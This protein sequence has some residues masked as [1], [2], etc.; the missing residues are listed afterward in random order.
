MSG[1][2][3]TTA[4]KRYQ[5]NRTSLQRKGIWEEFQD[6]LRQYV[7]LDHTELVPRPPPPPEFDKPIGEIYYLSMHRVKKKSS[8]TTKLRQPQLSCVSSLTHRRSQQMESHS[9]T[10]WNQVPL[11]IPICPP[12]CH[13]SGCLSSNISKMFREIGLH[14]SER[15]LHRFLLADQ[16]GV[17]SDY[18]MKRLTFGVTSSPFLATRVLH[19]MAADY[20]ENFMKAAHLILEAL[21]DN[22]CLTRA[23]TSE[24]ANS[25][26]LE[27]NSLLGHRRHV[28]A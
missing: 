27:L 25:I 13:I 19:Q 24:E 6:K 12:L 26:R 3:R 1:E 22:Y 15:Y 8:T 18:R 21:N 16:S 14:P 2:F 4:Y 20:K 5:E 10:C 7:T 23:D 9:M 11:F 17:I 28:S